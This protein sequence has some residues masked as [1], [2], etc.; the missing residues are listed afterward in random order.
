MRLPWLKWMLIAAV[1]LMSGGSGAHSI[2]DHHAK[3]APCVTHRHHHD[4]D[5]HPAHECC[6]SCPACPA[7]LVLPAEPDAPHSV[8]YDLRLAPEPASPLASRFSSP[9][10]DPPRP[11]A[12]S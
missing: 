4:G 10:L 9:E 5:R 2:A 11:G 12:L 8:A 3:A 7:D 6:C 1:L